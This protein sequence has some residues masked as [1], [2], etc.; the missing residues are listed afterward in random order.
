M[1]MTDRFWAK[2]DRRGDDECWSWTGAMNDR[3]YGQIR[4]GGRGSA[5]LYAH[6]VAYELHN[7]PI[8]EGEMVCHHCDNRL[9][10]NPAHLF[11]GSAADNTADML[12]KGRERPWG[13][14]VTACPQG[15]AYD[16]SNTYR[17]R[18]GGRQC[19]TCNR[20]RSREHQRRLRA[21]RSGAEA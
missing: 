12:A 17:T 3:G 1:T 13:R 16:E 6:R 8:A 9:C 2:V 20:I 19:K 11:S 21:E 4:A 15:H 5:L 18:A 14:E 10:C 7:G